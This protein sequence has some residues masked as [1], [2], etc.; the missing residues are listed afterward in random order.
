M[1]SAISWRGHKKINPLPGYKIY[2]Q[3]FTTTIFLMD[4]KVALEESKMFVTYP[5]RC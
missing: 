4:I 1:L 2:E 3:Q 5:V